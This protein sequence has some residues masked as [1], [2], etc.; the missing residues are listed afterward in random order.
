MTPAVTC[1]LAVLSESKEGMD[2]MRLVVPVL[3]DVES[4]VS[5]PGSCRETRDGFSDLKTFAKMRFISLMID[6]KEKDHLIT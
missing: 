2:G 6:V 4:A 5:D 1:A 3:V